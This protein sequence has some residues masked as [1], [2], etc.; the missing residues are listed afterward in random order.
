MH[1]LILPSWYITASNPLSGIFFKEQAESLA[2]YGDKV[3]VISIQENHIRSSFKQKKQPYSNKHFL[4]NGINT[5]SI[6]YLTIPRFTKIKVKIK[7]II[8][9]KI[10]GKYIKD[11]G[12]P[13]IVHVHSFMVGEFAIWIKEK[14]NIPYVVTEHYSGFALNNISNK[15]LDKANK[16]FEKSNYNIAV[17]KNFKDL[18]ENKFKKSFTYLPNIVNIHFFEISDKNSEKDFHFINIAFI[19]KNKNQ[20]MLIRAFTNSFAKKSHIKLTIVGDGPEYE[21]LK[22]LIKKLNMEN[23]IFLYGKASRDEVKTLLQK[24]DAFVLSSRY[25][26]FGIVMIEAMACGLP[27]I[28]T[29][30][31]GAESIVTSNKVGLL[32]DI[33]EMQLSKKINEL[34]ENRFNYDSKYIREYVE[35]NFSEEIVIEKLKEIYSKVLNEGYKCQE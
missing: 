21:R 8:F 7:K 1:I 10:F 27:V 32:S 15:D 17:S 20:D 19:N 23:Q 9:K 6:E 33:N 3:G 16:V 24:T 11:N 14:Y 18:L 5:Y 35:N 34:Y 26:T 13:D 2:K 22:G 31:G 30:C 29:K 25:E 28:A 12:L 4:E